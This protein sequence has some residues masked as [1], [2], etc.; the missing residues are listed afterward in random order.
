MFR[1]RINQK[2][3][4]ASCLRDRALFILEADCKL[5]DS[6]QVQLENCIRGNNSRNKIMCLGNA[7][8][9]PPPGSVGLVQAA[10][11]CFP[12]GMNT[13]TNT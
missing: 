13:A 10:K 6:G 1:G 12:L 3:T 2:P 4:I 8:E 9:N 5:R 7:A 11:S